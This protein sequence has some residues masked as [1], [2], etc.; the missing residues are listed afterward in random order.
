MTLTPQAEQTAASFLYYQLICTVTSCSDF[1][2]Q[3]QFVRQGKHSSCPNLIS[4]TACT[5]EMGF[6]ENLRVWTL[7]SVLALLLNQTFEGYNV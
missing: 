5:F 4:N 7:P 2:S 1:C 3:K 6:G